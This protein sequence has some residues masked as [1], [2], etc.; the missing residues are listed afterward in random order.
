MGIINGGESIHR[1]VCI[2]VVLITKIRRCL[3]NCQWPVYIGNKVVVLRMN[4]PVG[5]YM[6]QYA[7][8]IPAKEKIVIEY[9]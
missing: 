2:H 1:S 6:V 8:M 9:I 3:E 5:L 4:V 7:D